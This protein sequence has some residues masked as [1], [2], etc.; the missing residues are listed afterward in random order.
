MVYMKARHESRRRQDTEHIQ[1]SRM[2]DI[3]ELLCVFRIHYAGH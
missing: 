1:L 2:L 3:D